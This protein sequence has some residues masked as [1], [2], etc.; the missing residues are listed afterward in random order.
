LAAIR[1]TRNWQDVL[2]RN[3]KPREF[4]DGL[5]ASYDDYPKVLFSRYHGLMVGKHSSSVKYKG[6]AVT[7]AGKSAAFSLAEIFVKEEY[8]FIDA[9][10]KIVVDIG[11]N[12]GDTA[13]FFVLNGANHIYAFEPYPYSYGKALENIEANGVDD[14]VTLLRDGVGRKRTVRLPATYESELSIR[15]SENGV[16]TEIITLEELVR[17][18]PVE[19]S[20]LKMD[21]EGDEYPIIL[22]SNDE[23]LRNFSE[24][25]L[26]YHY[27]YLN[28]EKRLQKAGFSTKRVNRVRKLYNPQT[29]NC[30][31]VGLMHAKR[32]D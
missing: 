23:T 29:G 2:L 14:R 13:I 19:D 24:I 3:K 28:L 8:W 27:G 11:A 1:L 26:E 32:I 18:Y 15:E 9:S 10:G 5:T 4:R 16:P 25:V 30:M 17:G 7:L 21:C 12:I 31:Y 22:E 6:R 20:I